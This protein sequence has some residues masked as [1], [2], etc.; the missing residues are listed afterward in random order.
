[1]NALKGMAFVVA[2][3]KLDLDRRADSLTRVGIS[4]ESADT[5]TVSLG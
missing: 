4:I 1:M 5:K 2:K 3:K